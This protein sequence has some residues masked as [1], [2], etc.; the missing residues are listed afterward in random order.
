MS[1]R[2][3]R[4][5]PRTARKD[6]PSEGWEYLDESDYMHYGLTFTEYRAVIAAKR[7]NWKI[8]KGE[9]YTERVGTWEGEI[10]HQRL[11]PAIDAILHKYDMW[12]DC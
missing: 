9:V 7:N 3:I 8:L 6:H 2:H 10:C 12:R 4:D 5:T 1:W 11:I